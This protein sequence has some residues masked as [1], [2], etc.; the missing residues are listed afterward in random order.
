MLFSA[1][2][3]DDVIASPSADQEGDLERAALIGITPP[4]LDQRFV[5]KTGRTLIGRGEDNDIVL[6]DGSVSA[7]HAWILNEN[8]RHR[9]MNMLSTN[10][11]FINDHKAHEAPL[12][13]GDRIRLGRAEFVFRAGTAG[14]APE[15]VR[16]P[17]VPLWVWGAAA[18][19]VGLAV[20]A[21]LAL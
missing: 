8:G 15:A 6:P 16:A 12:K 21:V 7:Q 17:A 3:L 5:L 18:M 14:P 19:V 20:A 1:G 11:T 9:L 4:F 10:G 2:E 13:D